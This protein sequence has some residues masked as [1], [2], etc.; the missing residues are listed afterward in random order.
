MSFELMKLRPTVH[1]FRF[2]L[3]FCFCVIFFFI[4]CKNT[5]TD[6]PCDP[7]QATF[8][9]NLLLKWATSDYS[10]TC[11]KTYLPSLPK[12]ILEYSI[13]S[14][15]TKGL[16]RDNQIVITSETITSIASYVAQF[17]TNGVSVTVNGVEQI[18]GVTSNSYAIPLRYTVKAVDG[19]TNEYTVQMVAPRVLGG[20][21]LRLW[22]KADQLT[23]NDGDGI[24][25]WTDV[26]GYGNHIVQANTIQRPVFRMNQVKGYPVAEF[27]SSNTSR[28]DL[29]SGAVGLY[30]TNSGSVFFVMRLVNTVTGGITLLNLHG[31]QG[32]EISIE[33]PNPEYLVCRNGYSCITVSALP[34]LKSHFL[35]IG[36]VQVL[37]STVSEYWNGIVKGQVPVVHDYSG[38]S[39]ANTLYLGNGN[40]D[41]DIAEVLFFNTDLTETDVQKLFFY[42][43]TKYGL[44]PL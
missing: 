10:Q 23:L 2:T 5:I 21:S 44:S 18:S 9:N 13:P 12:E 17:K 36:S 38:G 30:V 6:N 41:A 11:G 24:A 26:S 43:N 37:S 25:T 34:I 39:P 28:M 15:G 27:R 40:L 33:H 19:S 16:I 29:S 1:L 42:L 4:S 31:G 20:G 8:R 35:A 22:F 14:L 7:N 3:P 32:R